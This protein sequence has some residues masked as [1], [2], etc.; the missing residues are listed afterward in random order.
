MLRVVC[1]WGRKVRLSI[2]H[3][4]SVTLHVEYLINITLMMVIIPPQHSSGEGKAYS[5]KTSRS[6]ECVVR[7]WRG[8][9]ICRADWG[10]IIFVGGSI[11]LLRPQDNVASLLL[12]RH[13]RHDTQ[14]PSP[15]PFLLTLT[16]ASQSQRFRENS[17]VRSLLQTSR[18]ALLRNANLHLP[19]HNNGHLRRPLL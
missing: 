11:L 10:S 17:H 7:C 8:C 18:L 4:V 3:V 1:R 2:S 15:R 13:R 16:I 19:R 12:C 14:S 6:F 9:S 5:R